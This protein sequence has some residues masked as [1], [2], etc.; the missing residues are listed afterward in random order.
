VKIPEDILLMGC[1]N[2]ELSAMIT[3][4]LTSIVQPIKQMAKLGVKVLCDA[5]KEELTEFENIVLEPSILIRESTVKI[6]KR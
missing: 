5:I 4:S 1:D 3:P 6:S 2:D